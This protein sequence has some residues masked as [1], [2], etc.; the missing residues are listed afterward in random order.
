MRQLMNDRIPRRFLGFRSPA[1]FR[2]SVR[3]SCRIRQSFSVSAAAALL[4]QALLSLPVPRLS[5]GSRASERCRIS[6]RS[7]KRSRPSS[8]LARSATFLPGSDQRVVSC[9]CCLL[10]WEALIILARPVHIS[11]SKSRK[12][13]QDVAS[14]TEGRQALV[15]ARSIQIRERRRLEANTVLLVSPQV[16]PWTIVSIG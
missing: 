9:P 15:D 4:P 6:G 3:S 14:G 10:V 11:R 2:P 8:L 7:T 16:N 13:S 12:C 1:N 5:M